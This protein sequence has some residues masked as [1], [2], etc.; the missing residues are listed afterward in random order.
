[1]PLEGILLGGLE[2]FPLLGQD[3][4]QDGATHVLH[5]AQTLHQGI[6][7][8]PLNGPYIPETQ[9]LEEHARHEDILHALIHF[10]GEVLH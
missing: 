4:N 9:L 2:P 3:V 10:I 5:G 7:V 8:M 6:Q 1:M